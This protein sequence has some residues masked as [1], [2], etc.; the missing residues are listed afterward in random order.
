MLKRR[1]F[2]W[3]SVGAAAAYALSPLER[4]LFAAPAVPLL[5]VAHGPSPAAI[6]RAAIEALGGMRAFVHRGD[7]VV[8]KPNIGWDRLPEHAADTN[9]E[10][11]AT[12]VAL[13]LDAGAKSVLVMD[14]PCNDPRRCYARSGIAAAAK[15]AGARVEH[16][17]EERTK[18]V[19][20]GGEAL[21]EW[22]VHRAFIECDVRINVPIVKHHGLAG[23]TGGMKNWLGAIGGARN[24]LHQD[25]D[26]SI[27]DLSAY[28]KPA[29]TVV[30]GV[31]LLVRGG[32][33]GGRLEDI[34]RGD[35]VIASADAVAA[36]ARG[37]ALHGRDGAAAPQVVLA[38]ARGLGRAT[39]AE[40]DERRLEVAGG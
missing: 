26:R 14:N 34:E 17:E 29:L 15:A 31:R 35:T 10:V 19:A 30:D 11:V 5:A 28:F 2:L 40:T 38:A 20:I 21:K 13:C 24:K 1:E 4:S 8:V 33:Q 32:P 12:V 27:V 25:L 22:P 18:R 9:P 3:T 39:W 6:T 16:F 36:E 23:V 37:I 7:R